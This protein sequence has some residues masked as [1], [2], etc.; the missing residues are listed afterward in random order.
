MLPWT[1]NIP[2]TV[3]SNLIIIKL[4][5]FLSGLDNTEYYL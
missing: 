4:Y 5:P 2:G 3:G 1:E